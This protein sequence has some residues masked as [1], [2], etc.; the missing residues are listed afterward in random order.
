MTSTPLTPPAPPPDSAAML[1][2]AEQAELERFREFLRTA[3]EMVDRKQQH[4]DEL[5]RLKLERDAALAEV[6]RLR[7]KHKEFHARAQAAER[8][9]ADLLRCNEKLAS[10]AAWCGGSLGRAFL[11]HANDQLRS[12]V[13]ALRQALQPFAWVGQ[14]V[15][16]AAG[17]ATQ[18]EL[19]IPYGIGLPDAGEWRRAALLAA[20]QP[21][22][23][24]VQAR[25][26]SLG[27]DITTAARRVLEA[28]ERSKR[29]LTD[30]E[31]NAIL[32]GAA[33]HWWS[34]GLMWH[35]GGAEFSSQDGQ[36]FF[37]PRPLFDLLEDERDIH[38]VNFATKD[39]AMDAL[40]DAVRRYKETQS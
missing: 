4:V 28:V 38:A 37:I 25:L 5:A 32:E 13:A 17:D 12:E 11:A 21:P 14:H 19:A 30:A 1:A 29:P 18:A 40:R 22:R 7:Q 27:I 2:D 26:A 15:Y 8:A 3:A 39:A 35:K 23:E 31:L 33:P 20:A 24:E 34:G 36:C 9:M 10:G 16:A 6:E